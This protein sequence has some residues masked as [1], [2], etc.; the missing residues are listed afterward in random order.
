MLLLTLSLRF[1]NLSPPEV[2]KIANLRQI[3][4]KC[5]VCVTYYSG[6]NFINHKWIW[7]L[8]SKL[9]FEIE[10]HS[11]PMVT[12]F[13]AFSRAKLGTVSGLKNLIDFVS[14]S[15]N[16]NATWRITLAITWWNKQNILPPYWYL[17]EG[18]P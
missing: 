15:W 16:M 3:Q 18:W 14:T 11:I 9:H 17:D 4:S 1:W 8:E 12:L 5:S 7:L 13:C 10:Y 6:L 2:N